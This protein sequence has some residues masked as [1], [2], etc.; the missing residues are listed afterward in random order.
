MLIFVNSS[1]K[2][3]EKQHTL[4]KENQAFSKILR[5]LKAC[6]RLNG[7]YQSFLHYFLQDGVLL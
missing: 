2:F 1:K 3:K 5:Q 4:E 6:S 7:V